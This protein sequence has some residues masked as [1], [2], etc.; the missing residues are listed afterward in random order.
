MEEFDKNT[1]V[2]RT[3]YTRA[4]QLGVYRL[5]KYQKCI[6]ATQYI[7]HI[8]TNPDNEEIIIERDWAKRLELK[9][10]R[11]T[12]EVL[13]TCPPQYFALRDELIGRGFREDEIPF[14]ISSVAKFKNVGTRCQIE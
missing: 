10:D 13:V 4:K 2:T 7:S 6:G 14:I 3:Y 8:Y 5:T 12:G 1:N 9:I 11:R